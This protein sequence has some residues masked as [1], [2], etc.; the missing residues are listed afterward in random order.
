MRDALTDGDLS[1]L[2]R[3]LDM[4]E[5]FEALGIWPDGIG[6][7]S[8]FR[9][10]VRMGLLVFADWGCDIDG[11]TDREVPIFSLTEEGRCIAW[12]YSAPQPC[13]RCD[14]P[15]Y[16]ALYC[17]DCLTDGSTPTREEGSNG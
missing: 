15:T 8:H 9:R 6:Q 1:T 10:L 13:R 2:Y 17:D 7:F 14:E 11:T 16:R 5:R 4:E 12:Q 3:A